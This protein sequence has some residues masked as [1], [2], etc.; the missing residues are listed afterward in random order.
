MHERF[1]EAILAGDRA[2]ALG[3]ARRHMAAG[4]DVFY[5]E[6]V[7][8]AL[9]EVGERW[10]RGELSVADEHLATAIA[11][12]VIA[13][14]YPEFP[15]RPR[16]PRALV[17]TAPGDRHD[18]GARMVADLLALDGWDDVYLGAD[19]PLRAVVEKVRAAK[20]SVVAV[21]VTL[22][23]HLPAARDLVGALREAAP[24][25]RL[26]VGGRAVAR[27]PDPVRALGADEWASSARGAVN[28]ARPW[29]PA[30]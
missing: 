13:A 30:A 14:L 25:A 12:S 6:V 15:W 11:Q 21:S 1:L 17:A 27:L 18:L 10:Y 3:E 22:P 19:T 28:V 2:A 24:G 29:K 26:V 20:P 9:G 8:T 4:L 16:G 7:R 5:E 23:L